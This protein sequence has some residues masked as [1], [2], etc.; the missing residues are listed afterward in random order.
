MNMKSPLAALAALVL[1]VAAG[2]LHAQE[3]AIRKNLSERLPTLGKIEE[4]AKSPIQGLWE[5]RVG[6]DI[7]YTDDQGNYLVQGAIFDTRAKRNLT[8]EREQKLMAVDF[9]ALPLKDAF[10]I[11]RGNGARKIAIFEDPNCGYCKRFERDLQKIDN[12]TVY[13]FLYP[14]LGGDSPEKSRNHWCTADKGHAWQD[15]MVRDKPAPVAMGACDTGAIAR[16]LEFG[17]KHKIQG[18]PT[19]FFADGTRL[20]GAVPLAQVEKMLAQAGSGGKAQ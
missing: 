9:A 16:N 3:A 5:V 2:A 11:V 19:T 14:I 4:V 1:L 10:I 7:Y 6:T 18:T 17:R 8:E 20:P 15:W 12:V 13:M